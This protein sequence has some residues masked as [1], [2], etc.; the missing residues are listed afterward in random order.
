MPNSNGYSMSEPF[1]I[2]GD[3]LEGLTPQACFVRGVECEQVKA[4][5]LHLEGTEMKTVHSDSQQR[6]EKMAE[7][8]GKTLISRWLNDDWIEISVVQRQGG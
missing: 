5:L 4:W 6:Y 2:D 3:E 7:R 1:N 8:R